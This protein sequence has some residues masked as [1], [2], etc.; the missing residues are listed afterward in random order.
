MVQTQQVRARRRIPGGETAHSEEQ[1][2]SLPAVPREPDGVTGSE[3]LKSFRSA[4]L[5]RFQLQELS[6]IFRKLEREERVACREFSVEFLSAQ[7]HDGRIC[8]REHTIC[9][10]Q[11]D[12]IRLPL[13]PERLRIKGEQ[14]PV[15]AVQVGKDLVIIQGNHR[16]YKTLFE[17]PGRHPLQLVVF[18]DPVAWE[19]FF[20]LP[21]LTASNG[22]LGYTRP[23]LER[24]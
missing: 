5:G 22:R 12:Q 18:A 4:V 11:L 3:L 17:N 24:Y 9:Q 10:R 6:H 15:M 14:G 1:G 20:D 23:R 2:L 7:F 19:K 8:F 21:F 16:V 13:Q